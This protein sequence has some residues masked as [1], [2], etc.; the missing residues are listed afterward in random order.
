M[1]SMFQL[2]PFQ[3]ETWGF[4]HSV[5]HINQYTGSPM[6]LWS[7]IRASILFSNECKLFQKA[8]QSLRQ[9]DTWW[10]YLVHLP[11]RHARTCL[12]VTSQW[13]CLLQYFWRGID[14]FL[15][16]MATSITGECNGFKHMSISWCVPRAPRIPG[17]LSP[18][19][20]GITGREK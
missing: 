19:Q 18:Q 1:H 17:V 11:S 8:L 2:F 14:L 3:T 20:V 13:T 7:D 5:T 4:H 12:N 10:G 16:D 15:H 9:T 6:S